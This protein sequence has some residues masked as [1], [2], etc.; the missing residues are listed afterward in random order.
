MK[1]I[2]EFELFKGTRRTWDR[3]P[4]TQVLQD[5][6]KYNRKKKHKEKINVGGKETHNNDR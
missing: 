4:G 3:H 5:K 6:T 2:T 1:K